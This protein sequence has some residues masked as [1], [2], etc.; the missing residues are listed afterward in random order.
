M[1]IGFI[2]IFYPSKEFHSVVWVVKQDL[3]ESIV[4]TVIHSFGTVVT[5]RILL[6]Y[7]FSSIVTPSMTHA[8]SPG[9]ET[10]PNSSVFFG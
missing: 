2:G 9:E 1:I 4:R 7:Y 3:S 5:Y 6:K 10:H 8:I